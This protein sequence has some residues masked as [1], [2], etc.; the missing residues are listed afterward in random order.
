MTVAGWSRVNKFALQ[1]VTKVLRG[2]LHGHGVV[3]AK[4][5]AAL[6]RDG[7]WDERVTKKSLK[8]A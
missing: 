1:S 7:F 2:D 5:I 4:I 3:G 8:V 6:R